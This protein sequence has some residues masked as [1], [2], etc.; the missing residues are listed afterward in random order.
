M[1][2]D[3][4]VAPGFLLYGEGL[5]MNENYTEYAVEAGRD[6]F[7]AREYETIYLDGTIEIAVIHNKSSRKQK[8]RCEMKDVVG[9]HIGKK[10]E[11]ARLGR[12][13]KDFSS[14]K[15]DRNCCI[16]KVDAGNAMQVICFEPGEE[17]T[18]ILSTRY[19]QLKI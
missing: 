19:R 7:G 15:K 13:T 2:R 4:R 3:K 14:K 9:F 6:F 16:M 5:D 12:I 18:E 11:A 10:E 17:L 8:F 1:A